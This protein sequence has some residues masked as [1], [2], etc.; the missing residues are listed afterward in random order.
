MIRARLHLRLAGVAIITV[1]VVGTITVFA[2]PA[3]AAVPG[4]Q[5]VTATSAFNSVSPKSVIATCPANKRVIDAGGEITNGGG[6]VVMDLVRPG[7]ST[8]LVRGDENHLAITRS[9]Q[10]RAWAVCAFAPAGLQLVTATSAFNSASPKAVTATC[11][12]GRSVIG[13]GGEIFNGGGDVA[14]DFVR[15]GFSAVTV[16]GDEDH[17]AIT[18]SWQVR[19]WAVC[20][21]APA[22][23]VLVTA[24]SAFNSVSP[25]V[26]FATCPAGRRA[27]GGGGEIF[28]G[29]GDV[30]MDL[31][32]PGF[33]TVFARG[34]EHSVVTSS[35][36]VR[37]WAICAFP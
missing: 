6:D 27:I 32:R 26:A 36:S 12:A 31:F 21:F 10:V 23:R 14:M 22:G 25:K 18:R 33:S 35:W 4:L 8:V 24:V 9:W 3:S 11:P 29:G 2:S 19:A 7:V 13:A 28:N 1:M 37:A 15:P 17:T 16:R 5:L 34:D 30:V 20:A